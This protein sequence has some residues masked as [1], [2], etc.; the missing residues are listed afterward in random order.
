M[1]K[2]DLGSLG[3]PLLLLLFVCLFHFIHSFILFFIKVIK[4]YGITILFCRDNRWTD[5]VDS[6][7]DN[8]AISFSSSGAWPRCFQRG[9]KGGGG[10]I[11]PCQIQST[12]QIA[13][14]TFHNSD[15][16]RRPPLFISSGCYSLSAI[17]NYWAKSR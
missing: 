8:W 6:F 3:I 12:R 10:V 17:V 13:I 16:L 9:G 15:I 7:L 4:R 14:S 5:L 2:I 11:T 1:V